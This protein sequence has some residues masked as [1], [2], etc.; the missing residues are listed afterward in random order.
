MANLE[1]KNR[2]TSSGAKNPN[3][4]MIYIRDERLLA[5]RELK[6]RSGFF[7]WCV[8]QKALR[9]EFNATVK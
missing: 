4:K 1:Y 6:N 3:A 7:N 8:G 5:D 2:K 9:D